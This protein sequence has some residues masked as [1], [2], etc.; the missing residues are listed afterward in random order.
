MPAHLKLT[1]SDYDLLAELAQGKSQAQIA[2]EQ[3]VSPQCVSDRLKRLQENLPAPAARRAEETVARTL[4]CIAEL[5]ASVAALHAIKASCERQLAG[6][7]G[8]LDVGPRDY[9]LEVLVSTGGR[10]PVRRPL[11]DVL[12]EK[13][14][15][16]ISIEGRFADPR[17]LLVSVIG[18]IRQH[19]ELAMRMQAQMYN[20]AETQRF[21]EEVLALIARVNPAESQAIKEALIERRNLRL[22]LVAPGDPLP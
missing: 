22:A 21:Q 12:G 2:Q 8:Q 14:D 5:H 13:S 20:A 18:Q 9:D 15:Q 7:D 4:D 16:L 19:L 6:E 1:L 3:D 17:T 11:R 10:P